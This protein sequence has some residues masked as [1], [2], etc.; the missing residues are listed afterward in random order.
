MPDVPD[1]TFGAGALNP[2]VLAGVAAVL[3]LVVTAAFVMPG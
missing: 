3:L 1:L 2:A